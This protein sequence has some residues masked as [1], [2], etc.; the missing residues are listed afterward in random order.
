MD[1]KRVN[2]YAIDAMR[3]IAILAV[4]MIHTSSRALESVHF[5][6]N[7]NLFALFLNQFSRFTVPLF[8]LISGFV[9]ELN[10]DEKAGFW[11][12]LKKRFNRILIPYLFWGSIYY[13][14]VYSTNPDTFLTAIL[15][16]S[17]SYQL[18]FIPALLVFYVLF[19]LLHKMYRYISNGW[20]L[21]FLGTVEILIL[22]Q[23]YYL[24]KIHIE[25]SLAVVFFNFLV[26]FIGM[27]ASRNYQKL[28]N[29]F[30]RIKYYLLGGTSVLSAYIFWEGWHYYYKTWNIDSFYSSWRPSV[31]I[32]TLFFSAITFY[33]FEKTRFAERFFKTASK[34]SFFVFFAHVIILEEAWKLI[35]PIWKNW[36]DLPFFVVVAAA[37]FLVAYIVHKIPYLPKLTG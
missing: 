34:L 16:G 1:K 14:L 9:L 36:Y 37:S 26:F 6:L 29:I 30:G 13:F 28:F 19:P 22:F 15:T 31:L 7:G 5:D 35:A 4:V 17:A 25:Y 12:Y 10:Y 24:K 18:Y 11:E 2:V 23:E 21:S 20:I 27:I 8:F 33:F 3:A 32:Y